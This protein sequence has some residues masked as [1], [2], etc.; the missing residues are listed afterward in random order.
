MKS[1]LNEETEGNEE[2]VIQDNYGNI[3]GEGMIEEEGMNSSANAM[4]LQ[5]ES[6]QK[7]KLNRTIPSPSP[8]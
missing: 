1:D 7:M 2:E 8:Y 6:H 4:P 3:H 5:L